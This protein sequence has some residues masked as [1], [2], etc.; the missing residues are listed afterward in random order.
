MSFLIGPA[1]TK[2]N[3]MKII[4]DNRA[5]DKIDW[6]CSYRDKALNAFNDYIEFLRLKDITYKN[7]TRKIWITKTDLK[8]IKYFLNRLQ[9][10]SIP[11]ELTK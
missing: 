6:S 8:Y 9:F 11:F 5:L 2:E 3:N 10:E 7:K 4:F 1:L